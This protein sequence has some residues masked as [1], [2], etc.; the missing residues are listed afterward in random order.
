MT[1]G[2]PR[3][4][5]PVIHDGPRRNRLP[6]R[7]LL[8]G[9]VLILITGI[10]IGFIYV[11][12]F[13]VVPVDQDVL[14]RTTPGSITGPRLQSPQEVVQRY[15]EALR[16]GNI[17]SALALGPRG[18][19][20]RGSLVT[21]RAFEETRR[22][23]PIDDIE[24]TADDPEAVEVQVSYTLGGEPVEESVRV[25]R[26]DDGTYQMA[27]TTT[28]VE[29]DVTGGQSL[30]MIVNGQRVGSNELLEVVPGRYEVSTGLP[31]ITYA[32]PHNS[33]TVTSMTPS[34]VVELTAIPTL[35]PEGEHELVQAARSSLASC[36]ELRQLEPADCPN[37]ITPSA[38]VDESTVRWELVNDPWRRLQPI[39]HPEDQTVAALSTVIR[40]NVTFTYSDGSSSGNNFQIRTAQIRA[41]MAGEP[42]ADIVIDWQ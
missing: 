31:F 4:V 3:F 10:A 16:D 22:I 15:F 17:E 42:P 39:L 24:V 34:E 14:V 18:G 36:L 19:P 7:A 1:D 2:G 27:Q 29:F 33:F 21:A 25:T 37:H 40:T 32:A 28:T 20:G 6:L 12:F 38:P 8:L 35:T 9:L 41:N 11:R 13:R 26:N 5:A 23:S 30:P